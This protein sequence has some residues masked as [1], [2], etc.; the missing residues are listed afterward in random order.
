MARLTTSVITL[1][2]PNDSVSSYTSNGTKVVVAT[3]VR[4]SAQR[5]ASHSPTISTASSEA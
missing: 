3:K 4:Y 5:L 1:N 2:Q